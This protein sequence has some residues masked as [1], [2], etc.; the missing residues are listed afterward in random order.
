MKLIQGTVGICALAA[1]MFLSGCMS[2]S[3]PAPIV[4]ATPGGRSSAIPRP[5]PAYPSASGVVR[6]DLAGLALPPFDEFTTPRI[7]RDLP[8]SECVPYARSRSAIQI[9][10]DAVTWWSQAEGR[11]HR[12]NTPASGS[13]LVLKGY[14]DNTRG[15]VS[16]VKTILS[17]RMIRVDHA[18]WLGQGETTLDVPVLDVSADN[19]WSEVR[20]WHVPGMHW[21]GRIYEAEGFIHPLA[22]NLIG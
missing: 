5:Y 2:S 10:G 17:P 9:W 21:G 18:N 16:V 14:E 1:G 11:Y 7:A 15:H 20:I 13:I 3:R 8:K 6:P 22:L 4:Y 19:D 12:S